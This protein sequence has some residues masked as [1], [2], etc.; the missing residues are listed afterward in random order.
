MEIYHY[1]IATHPRDVKTNKF[2]T[3]LLQVCFTQHTQVTHWVWNARCVSHNI[4]RSHLGCGCE[5]PG[6]FHTTCSGCT[7]SLKCQVCFTQHAQ[8]APWVWVWKARCV[9]HNMLRSHLGCGC[10]RPGV[11]H[12]TCSG[13]TLSLKCQVC[14]ILNLVMFWQVFNVSP[15]EI[16]LC[17]IEY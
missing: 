1:C 3:G 11:F 6:V 13:C 17:K 7:L 8:V 2:L 10:E 5:R 4:L 12:T 14:F 16:I 9:S 15:L